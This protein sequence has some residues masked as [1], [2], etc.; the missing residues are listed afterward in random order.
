MNK[1]S[2]KELF[3]LMNSYMSNWSDWLINGKMF[4][5]KGFRI[6]E[7]KILKQTHKPLTE[8]KLYG[9]M[10]KKGCWNSNEIKFLCIGF[11]KTEQYCK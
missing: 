5:K 8:N 4:F 3:D 10:T 7:Q 2:E 11:R 6:A 1:I 9:I